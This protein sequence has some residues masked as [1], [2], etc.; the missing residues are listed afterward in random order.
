[1]YANLPV[2]DARRADPSRFPVEIA[3]LLQLIR[4][5]C[6]G[7]AGERPTMEQVGDLLGVSKTQLYAYLAAPKTRRRKPLLPPYTLIYALRAMAAY[8]PGTRR[9]LWPG[10]PGWQ[11]APPEADHG[12]E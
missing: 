2:P 9:A 7:P 1:M 8:L 5:E 11:V 10:L 12:S 4:D 6:P 3:L